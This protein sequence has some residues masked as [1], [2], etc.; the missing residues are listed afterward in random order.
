MSKEK[1]QL[2]SPLFLKYQADYEKNPR[3][4]VFA[5]LA[6]T[7]RKIGMTEKAME[8]LS[9]GIRFHPAYVMGY[10]GLAFCY[11]DLKQYNLAYSTLRPVAQGNRDN[12]RLQKLFGDVCLELGYKEE[13]LE[14]YK[15]L[16]FINPRDKDI[17]NQVL[18]LEK[19][20]EDQYRP[21]HQP[22][23]IPESELETS[24]KV[25]K[26]SLLFDV[27]KLD[28]RPNSTADDYDNWISL[29]L[30]SDQK[31]I[32]NEDAYAM[33]N[34]KKTNETFE[35]PISH[36]KSSSL[37]EI[38]LDKTSP[39][40]ELVF[41]DEE[42]EED[43]QERIEAKEN[44]N[45]DLLDLDDELKIENLENIE[46][47][48]SP[49]RENNGI[50]EDSQASIPLVTHTLVDLYCGQ[51]HIEKALQV[52]EKI[53][54]LNPND[55]KTIAK[56]SEIRDLM[57]PTFGQD[58]LEDLDSDPEEGSNEDHGELFEEVSEEDGRKN[59]MDIFD[60]QMGTISL[61]EI[62]NVS[63]KSSNKS[64]AADK[65]RLLEE[66][67]SLFLRKIQK[68]ALDYQERL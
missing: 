9:Q 37:E 23:F 30:G 57:M 64:N 5:P 42:N 50:K 40:L 41:F 29:D 56:I 51:G 59:L 25:D 67:L 24:T 60:Q 10:L 32:K 34:L 22:I 31:V 3:S 48:I 17:A 11:Y 62:V 16:L 43:D 12:I 15:Y 55:Q 49:D 20:I 36:I 7:Y 35:P 45:L 61:P 54:L 52:L 4:R 58:N 47:S 65:A 46:F 13:A 14:T 2:L 21:K 44:T 39:G 27:D 33:W 63:Q 26:S 19:T 8:I 18:R 28:N 38:S 6:E 1:H 66:K 68:R 53:L